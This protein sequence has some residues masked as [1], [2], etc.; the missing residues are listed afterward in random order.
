[1]TPDDYRKRAADCRARVAVLPV[2]SDLR[3]Q[4]EYL[5]RQWDSMAEHTPVLPQTK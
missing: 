4:F 5:A 2:G 1:M 3:D